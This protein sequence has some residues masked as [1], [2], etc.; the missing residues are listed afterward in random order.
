M[1][2]L[3]LLL[4][5]NE[6]I[7]MYNIL[8]CD[9]EADIRSALRIYLSSED[10]SIFE[11]ENGRQALEIIENENIHLLLMDIMMPVM[12]G[13]RALAKLREQNNNIPVI[14]LT[15]K[16]QDTDKILGLNAGADDYITK[17]FNP[18][19]VIARVKSQLR[20]YM[21]FGGNNDS[22]EKSS[23]L[24][25]GG[26]ELDDSS[27]TFSRDGETINLTPTEMQLL[28]FF[29]ENL[30]KVFSPKEIYRKVCLT[31]SL[32]GGAVAIHGDDLG[33]RTPPGLFCC[34]GGDLLPAIQLFGKALCVRLGDTAAAGEGNDL[35]SAQLRGFLDHML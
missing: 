18:I 32:N 35:I 1:G 19:E 27:K 7:T 24:R 13:I 8:I 34:G 31:G 6:E 10:Y 3:K 16:S 26:L 23:V 28:K 11:A 17:P 14:L 21:R 15:A 20:R 5:K 29:M 22:A 25:N 9:D 2:C 33:D 4:P 12:D 30:D